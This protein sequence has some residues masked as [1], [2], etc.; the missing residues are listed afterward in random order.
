[1]FQIR[2]DGERFERFI[3]KLFR[4]Q[5]LEAVA[6]FFTRKHA[7]L[8]L[9]I[10][11]NEFEPFGPGAA[12]ALDSQ[13]QPLLGV[14]GDGQNA[15]RKVEL[16]RPQMEERLFTAA[17]YFPGHPRKDRNSP[18]VFKNFNGSGSGK[19]LETSSQ[20]S[21][22]FHA[23]D[24]NYYNYLENCSFAAVSCSPMT[25]TPGNCVFQEE[26]M[27]SK[28]ISKLAAVREAV[29]FQRPAVSLWTKG[30]GRW[31]ARMRS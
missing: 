20:F 22:E 23:L 5:L 13:R 12:E 8:P 11:A 15:A 31:A 17:A 2:S 28:E 7:C 29:R 10:R 9:K 24:Y 16:L 6:E 3:W 18:A 14:I 21:S 25:L 19:L 1:M 26:G 30:S 27:C 4:K